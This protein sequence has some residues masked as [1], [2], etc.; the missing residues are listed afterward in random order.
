MDDKQS[1]EPSRIERR[2]RRVAVPDP[3]GFP[4][5]G[6]IDWIHHVDLKRLV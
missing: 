4:E 1:G 3:S 5:N 2:V 6:R